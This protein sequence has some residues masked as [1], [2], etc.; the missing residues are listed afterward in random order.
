MELVSTRAV[1]AFDGRL[2]QQRSC[3]ATTRLRTRATSSWVETSSTRTGAGP[4]ICLRHCGGWRGESVAVRAATDDLG[5]V[6]GDVPAG[7]GRRAAGAEHR[8]GAPAGLELDP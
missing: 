6:A 2:A 3:P 5:A 7:G 8:A 1:G 4:A